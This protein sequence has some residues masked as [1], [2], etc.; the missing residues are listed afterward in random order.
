[1]IDQGGA[2]SVTQ[3][4][5]V[6]DDELDMVTVSES[7]T[8][9]ELIRFIRYNV[10]AVRVCKSDVAS[11][12]LQQ[13]TSGV[14]ESGI[15]DGKKA[16]ALVQEIQFWKRLA[17]KEGRARFASGRVPCIYAHSSLGIL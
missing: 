4:V 12:M 8:G 7:A 11:V 6:H 13:Q 3:I 15:E 9:H 10:I 2:F 16:A 14:S 17:P 1:M 5:K